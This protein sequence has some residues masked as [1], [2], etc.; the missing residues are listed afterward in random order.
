[1]IEEDPELQAIL[2]EEHKR[3][4]DEAL[5]EQQVALKKLRGGRMSSLVADVADAETREV[6]LT[7]F[8]VGLLRACIDNQ[9]EDLE[10]C[11]AT[12][13]GMLADGDPPE[14]VGADDVECVELF[15]EL[16]EKDVSNLKRIRDVLGAQK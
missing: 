13:E 3:W 7:K 6:R 15:K 14:D 5:A 12:Y 4:W 1:M 11:I 2:D 9:I 10:G 8:E 16:C